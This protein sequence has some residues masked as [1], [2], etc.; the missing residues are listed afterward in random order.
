MT[1]PIKGTPASGIAK[2]VPCMRRRSFGDP[3][4]LVSGNEVIRSTEITCQA[5][6]DKRQDKEGD[7]RHSQEQK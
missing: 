7:C 6:K 1:A 5:F 4:P 3:Y 2:A